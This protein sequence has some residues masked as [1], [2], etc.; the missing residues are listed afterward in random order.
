MHV[1]SSNKSPVR[2]PKILALQRSFAVHYIYTEIVRCETGDDTNIKTA[3]PATFAMKTAVRCD[4]VRRRLMDTDRSG[5]G[6]HSHSH[7]CNITVQKRQQ[8]NPKFSTYLM[9]YT[10]SHAKIH[11]SPICSPQNVAHNIPLYN[12]LSDILFEFSD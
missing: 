2:Y 1:I 4:A 12:K 5:T 11:Q 3:N 6:L 7:S 8:F 9:K 10:A